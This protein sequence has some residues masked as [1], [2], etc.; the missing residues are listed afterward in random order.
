MDAAF[1]SRLK[2]LQKNPRPTPRKHSFTFIKCR[3]PCPEGH[4]IPKDIVA[5]I[6]EHM[7]FI[8][9]RCIEH[10]FEHVRPEG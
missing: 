7:G 6:Q 8:F 1:I 5:W 3:V 10:F 9:R 4:D 2:Q